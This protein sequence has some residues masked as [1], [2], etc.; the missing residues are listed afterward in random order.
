MVQTGSCSIPQMLYKASLLETPKPYTSHRD[1]KNISDEWNADIYGRKSQTIK[2]K[3]YEIL[4]RQAA[5][6]LT[7]RDK[8]LHAKR[9]RVVSQAF[10][11]TNLREFEPAILSK[12]DR[13]CNSLRRVESDS[14]ATGRMEKAGWSG[15][16]DMAQKCESLFDLVLTS[17]LRSQ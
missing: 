17:P 5:N 8:T 3:N 9:R 11:G 12:I 14:S 15:T 10:S 2:F 1:V 7:L 13:F 6:L 16:M 4:S